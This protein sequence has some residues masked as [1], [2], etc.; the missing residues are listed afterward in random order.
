MKNLSKIL[1]KFLSIKIG[2]YFGAFKLFKEQNC[3]SISV[4]CHSMHTYEQRFTSE[5]LKINSWNSYDIDVIVYTDILIE[6]CD[7]RSQEIII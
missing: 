5:K 1:L 3:I 7:I 4:I 2:D 6:I